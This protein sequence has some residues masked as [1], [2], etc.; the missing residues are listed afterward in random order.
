VTA[1]PRLLPPPA[2]HR[3]LKWACGLP[4]RVQRRLFGAPP[5]IDGQ[6][7]ASDVQTLLRVAELVDWVLGRTGLEL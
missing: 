3:V 7:L 4:P 2:E 5:T 1:L 6:T